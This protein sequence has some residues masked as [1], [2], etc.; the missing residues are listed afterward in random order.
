MFLVFITVQTALESVKVKVNH[1]ELTTVDVLTNE[2][3]VLLHYTG[4]GISLLRLQ[5]KKEYASLCKLVVQS[6]LAMSLLLW[7]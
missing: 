2:K 1:S 5:S 6:C 7:A 4:M 3:N